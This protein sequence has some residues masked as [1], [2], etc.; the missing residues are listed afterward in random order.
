MRIKWTVMCN[1][2]F[3]LHRGNIHFAWIKFP[4]ILY[5]GSAQ[6]SPT[7]PYVRWRILY[8]CSGF[9]PAILSKYFSQWHSLVRKHTY[10]PMLVIY[11]WSRVGVGTSTHTHRKS[12]SVIFKRHISIYTSFMMR[13]VN[14][15]LSV[16]FSD[17][18]SISWPSIVQ[19]YTTCFDGNCS[20]SIRASV[21]I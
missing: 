17:G 12:D 3:Q 16:I 4:S 19:R 2:F 10:T 18:F 6:H 13:T 7:L 20:G 15:L 5:G 1:T 8:R 9:L 21:F 11:E 14:L